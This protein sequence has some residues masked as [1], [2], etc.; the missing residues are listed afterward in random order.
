MR[1]VAV[2]ALHP[3]P[4]AD[5]LRAAGWHPV[6]FDASTELEAFVRAGLAAGVLDLLLTDLADGS[7]GLDRLTAASLAGVPQVVAPGGLPENLPPEAADRLGLDVAQRVS[8]TSGPAAVLLPTVGL[9]PGLRVFAE[10]VGN[11]AYG[12]EL[13]DAVAE[14]DAPAFAATAADEV[15]RLLAR[16]R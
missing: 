9:T 6:V 16:H 4:A 10:S 13:R 7:A 14:V 15:L 3:G 2:H 1:A 5:R 11:W 12:F 8:A